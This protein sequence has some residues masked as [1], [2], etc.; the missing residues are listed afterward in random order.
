MKIALVTSCEER[1]GIA[2]YARNLLT[3]LY[4][5][6]PGEATFEVIPHTVSYGEIKSFIYERKCDVVHFNYEPGLFG[7]WLPQHIRSLGKPTLLT[8]HTSQDGSN[9]SEFTDSFTRV[10]VHEGQDEGNI[11]YIPMGI[12]QYK[13]NDVEE[14]CISYD[15]GTCGFP[16]PWK[17]FPEVVKACKLLGLRCLVIAP[18]SRHANALQ[19]RDQLHAIYNNGRLSVNTKWNTQDQVIA[20]LKNCKV[21]VFAYHGNNYGISAA[22]RLGLATGN[23]IIVSTSRQFRDLQ[24]YVDEI[25]FI[26]QPPD[27]EEIARAILNQLDESTK[28]VP[29]RVLSDFSF[30]RVGEMY[31]NQYRELIS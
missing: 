10:V 19:M 7:G 13:G 28:K 4:E 15:V 29:K 2:E 8:L 24:P 12:P 1:C 6:S 16:F 25:D 23:P 18:E 17:G 21:T 5:T 14:S 26:S 30:K 27:P 22:C 20:R 9:R 31:M 3:N 11:R